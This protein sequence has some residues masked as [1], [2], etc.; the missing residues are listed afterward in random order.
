M[1]SLHQS[2]ILGELRQFA[3]RS[4]FVPPKTHGRIRGNRPVCQTK[5]AP[6]TICDQRKLVPLVATLPI[7]S[8]GGH[9]RK[10]S[11]VVWVHTAPPPYLKIVYG[12]CTVLSYIQILIQTKVYTKTLQVNM[13]PAVSVLIL[14]RTTNQL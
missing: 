2:R 4:H 12:K 14:S 5:M 10:T 13:K 6:A 3:I 9:Y 8:C 11:I 1:V 7:H